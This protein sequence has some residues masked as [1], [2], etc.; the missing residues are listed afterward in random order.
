[1]RAGCLG[2]R[3]HLFR[4]PFE[5]IGYAKLRRNVDH[6]RNAEAHNH[7]RQLLRHLRRWR[8]RWHARALNIRLWF[9][10]SSSLY[11]PVGPSIS[12]PRPAPFLLWIVAPMRA[13]GKRFRQEGGARSTND[14]R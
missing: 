9:H 6:L 12:P 10:T 5:Q 14:T 4:A 3:A 2:Q 8:R 13:V 7:L 11:L 1:M